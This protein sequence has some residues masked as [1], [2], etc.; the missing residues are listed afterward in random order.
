MTIERRNGA[1]A[2]VQRGSA[3]IAAK[4]IWPSLAKRF[5][6]T[7]PVEHCSKSLS[8]SRRGK[9]SG[10]PF[11]GICAGGRDARVPSVRLG[12]AGIAFVNGRAGR[13]AD[14]ALPKRGE[15][16]PND[17]PCGDQ[18][19]RRD[20]DAR[21]SQLQ[22]C[23]GQHHEIGDDSR[24]SG[25]TVGASGLNGVSL[26]RR[27][28]NQT[29]EGCEIYGMSGRGVRAFASAPESPSGFHRPGQCISRH[30][31]FGRDCGDDGR[32]SRPQ[33]PSWRRR[34]T[35]AENDDQQQRHRRQ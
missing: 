30:Q 12:E 17:G 22:H 27:R 34:R 4:S 32:R 5:D 7:R 29:I 2:L 9:G 26:F 10:L 33:Q 14:N 20:L 31:P 35:A 25:G 15:T 6:A 21:F 13:K 23:A 11:T 19:R 24:L 18:C 3:A 8:T 1:S 16:N 28:A